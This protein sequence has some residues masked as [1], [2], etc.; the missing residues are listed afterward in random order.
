M[1]VT[2]TEAAEGVG[3]VPVAGSSEPS[4]GDTSNTAHTAN[5]AIQTLLTLPDASNAAIFA[6][7]STIGSTSAFA[8][9]TNTFTTSTVVG[10]SESEL[11]N[12]AV[13]AVNLMSRILTNNLHHR[14]VG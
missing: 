9:T 5:T 11:W 3:G 12:A 7:T 10:G 14:P 13:A 6:S 1:P 2:T 4:K 8:S